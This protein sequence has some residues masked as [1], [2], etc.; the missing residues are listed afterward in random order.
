MKVLGIALGISLLAVAHQSHAVPVLN[1]DNGHYYELIDVV[2]TTILWTD[3]KAISESLSH[4]GWPGHLVTITSQAETDF[5][6][7]PW[8]D[9]E[10]FNAWIG[11]SQLPDQPATDVGWQWVTGEPWGYTDWFISLGGDASPTDHPSKYIENNEENYL[12]LLTPSWPVQHKGWNDYAIGSGESYLV[13]YEAVIPEPSTLMLLSLGLL[14]TG[15]LKRG[16]KNWG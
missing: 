12:A 9:A 2:G 5:I 3:A 16:S 6:M 1:P 10:L 11:A 14:G 4:L 7:S 15:I 13:E 8:S